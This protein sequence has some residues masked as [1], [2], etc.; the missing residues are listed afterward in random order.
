MEAQLEYDTLRARFGTFS[1][2][3]YAQLVPINKI[4][5]SELTRMFIKSVS[6]VG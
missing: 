6:L 1:A 3:L 2:N 5:A 4:S